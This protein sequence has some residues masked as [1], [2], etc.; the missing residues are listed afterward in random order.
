MIYNLISGYIAGAFGAFVVLPIDIVK[1]NIQSSIVK[2]DPIQIIKTI[3]N[4]NGIRG[5]YKGGLTQIFLV[6]PEKAIKFTTNDI[7]YKYT[8]NQI[9]AGMCAG[10]SQVIIT[11]PMEILK[12]Q[13]Q[14]QSQSQSTSNK[15]NNYQTIIKNIGG[16]KN[17]Y[18]GASLC[19]MRDIPFSGIYF[20]TY[21]ILYNRYHIPDHIS[22]LIAGTIA[23][24]TVTPMDFIKTQV[25]YK[26][27][28]KPSII[29]KEIIQTNN[30]KLL[31]RGC[32]LRGFKSGPQFMITQTI[33][34]KLNTIY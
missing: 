31:F 22:G 33:Y 19:M 9:F 8:S 1:T 7:V 30:Y 23:A 11:N 34:N 26:I 13:M 5:F 14:M 16:I 20:P 6:A 32:M 29:I 4:Q 12:I 15:L 17:L 18:R 10:F 21:S 28:I 25:Q 3:Y 24:I 27:N 2:L